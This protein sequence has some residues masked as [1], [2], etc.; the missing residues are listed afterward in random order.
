MVTRLLQL[1]HDV[2]E[3]LGCALVLVSLF[4]FALFIFRGIKVQN[5]NRG[6]AGR[7]GAGRDGAGRVPTCKKKGRT[8]KTAEGTKGEQ[9]RRITWGKKEKAIG[10]EWAQETKGGGAWGGGVPIRR[11]P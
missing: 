4:G 6:G 3:A 11:L 2:L 9:G 1:H 5:K 8:A 7:G 10:T